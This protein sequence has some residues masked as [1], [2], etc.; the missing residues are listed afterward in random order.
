MLKTLQ[1]NSYTTHTPYAV[2]PLPTGAPNSQSRKKIMKALVGPLYPVFAE[3]PVLGSFP[4]MG[5]HITYG[6]N[7]LQWGTTTPDG[8]HFRGTL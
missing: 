5:T 4:V 1:K 2:T 7:R 6:A 3:N 8:G